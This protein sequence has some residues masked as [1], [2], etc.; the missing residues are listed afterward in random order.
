[1]LAMPVAS[2]SVDVADSN[3]VAVTNGSRPI[4]SGIHNVEKP[5]SSNR[6]AACCAS[7]EGI[8]SSTPVQMPTRP[9]SKVFMCGQYVDRMDTRAIGSLSVSLVG[10]GCNNFGGRID[11]AATKAVVDAAL[12]EGINFFD[13]ADIY[14]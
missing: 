8:A 10:I 5:S 13:T 6:P 7:D 2:L 1:M 12:D 9:R 14:G 3:N 4:V 11:A